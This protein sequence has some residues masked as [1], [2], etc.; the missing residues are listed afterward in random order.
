MKPGHKLLL[1]L[2]LAALATGMVVSFSS[3]SFAPAWT[4]AL[5]LGVVSLGFFAISMAVRREVARFD[6]EQRVETDEVRPV[7]PV[8]RTAAG[9]AEDS[10][11]IREVRTASW[12]HH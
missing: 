7:A 1:I 2:A 10:P 4:V 12:A 3:A 11:E 8:S 5:P 6:E 9:P